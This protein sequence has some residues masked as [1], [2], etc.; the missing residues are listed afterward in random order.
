MCYRCFKAASTCICE[1]VT[2]VDNQ[3]PVTILQHP[4]ERNHPIGTA[5]FAQLGLSRVELVVHGPYEGPAPV[6]AA[7]PPG[8]ALLYPEGDGPILPQDAKPSHLLVL[9]GTWHQARKLFQAHP[10][11]ATMPRFGLPGTHRSRYRIRSEPADH[12]LSTIEAITIALKA[13][14]PHTPGFDQLLGA[15]DQMIDEQ[16]A[17]VRRREPRRKKRYERPKPN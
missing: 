12:C 3:T 13:L 9:D 17:Y 16:E 11:L 7:L 4:R 5:R 8:A 10:T 15:F 14:E 1:S 6:V 2:R